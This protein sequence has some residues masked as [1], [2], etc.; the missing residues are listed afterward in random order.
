MIFNI[1]EKIVNCWPK[2]KTITE[3]LPNVY[4]N[5]PDLLD[6]LFKYCLNEKDRENKQ[7]YMMIL[8]KLAKKM[9]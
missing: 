3:K 7:L 2:V 1:L 9:P 8:S 6:K 5:F 4:P